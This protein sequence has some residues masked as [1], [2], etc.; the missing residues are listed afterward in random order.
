MSVS[1]ATVNPDQDD[2][3][4]IALA[5][6]SDRIKDQALLLNRK[7]FTFAN[8]REQ[9][10]AGKNPFEEFRTQA[11]YADVFRD[12]LQQGSARKRDLVENVMQKHRCSR[13]TASGLVSDA[14]GIGVLLGVVTLTRFIA[15][16]TIKESHD[17]VR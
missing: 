12:L 16:L 10:R 9:L 1:F 14:L 4:H 8:A 17:S 15:T 13:S 3:I 2:Q 11:A 5:D 7:G 6:V